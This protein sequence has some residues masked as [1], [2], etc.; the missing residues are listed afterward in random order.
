[1]FALCMNKAESE[2]DA[3]PIS[4]STYVSDSST[5]HHFRI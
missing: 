2:E 3:E 4:V 1:M 5:I